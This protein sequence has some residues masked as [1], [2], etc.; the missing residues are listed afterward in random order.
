M[1]LTRGLR[2][3]LALGVVVLFLGGLLLVVL[4][5]ESVLNIQARLGEQPS[6]LGFVWWGGLGVLSLLVGWLLWRLLLPRR[7][8]AAPARRAPA[9]SEADLE[10]RIQRAESIGADTSE[11]RAELARLRA[12][13]AAGEVHVVLFG[14]IST[15]K[16]ALIRA[17]LPG[18][19]TT[20]DVGGGTT[21]ELRRFRWRSSA[22]DALVLTDMPGT[23]EAGRALDA[24]ARD[25]ALRAHVVVY[26]C[27]GDLSRSQYAELEQLRELDKPLIVALNKADRYAPGELALLQQRL[28]ERLGV[29]ARLALVTVSAGGRR[30]ALR[31]GP[32]G[33]EQRIERE[34]PP[35]V[36]ELARAL[37]RMIDADPQALEQLRDSAVFVLVGRRLD[38]ATAAARRARAEELVEGYTKK[39]V[40]GALAAVTPGADLLIQGWLGTQ[41]VKELAALYEVKV[42]KVD[43]D[44]LLK[45]VQKHVG[46]ATTLILAVA[47]NALKAFPGV[48]TLAGGILHAVAYGMVFR[49]LGRAL[50]TTLDTRG[51]LHPVQTAALFKETLGEHLETSARGLARLAVQEARRTGTGD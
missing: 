48:G 49:T 31:L 29:G 15:G 38:E 24:L 23:A 22:G 17:L 18:A 16:S 5:T 12:R 27:D 30:E 51:E 9:T 42:A 26:V 3:L 34:F 1:R 39:A 13:R 25:E 7:R 46:K 10:T 37:Q 40:V 6:W 21:R 47:G 4:L 28:R 33:S 32:E 20:S 35:R 44:L 2:L 11:V 41:M 50:A 8:A 45:L 43:A 36:D 19:E 14:E